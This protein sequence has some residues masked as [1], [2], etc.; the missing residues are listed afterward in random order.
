M[1]EYAKLYKCAFNFASI[2]AKV[3]HI[4]THYF[5]TLEIIEY[6]YVRM[7]D[8]IKTDAYWLKLAEICEF[9]MILSEITELN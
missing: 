2:N 4:Y 6:F 9:V 3:E 7:P 8:A 5:L 1:L